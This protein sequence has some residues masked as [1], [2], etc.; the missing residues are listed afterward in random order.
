MVLIPPL[1]VSPV[2]RSRPVL[3]AYDGLPIELVAE[4]L[5]LYRE[6]FVELEI[7][8]AGRQCY[9]DA[10]FVEEMANPAVLKYVARVDGVAAAMVFLSNDLSTVPWISVPYYRHHFPDQ[11]RRQAIY[12]VGALLV[13]PEHRGG[14]ALTAVMHAAS[15]HVA[16]ADG[17]A[18]FDCCQHNVDALHLPRALALLA[19]RVCDVTEHKLDSQSFYAYALSNPK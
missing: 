13:H 15:R 11:F 3:Q 14:S 12:Y 5:A 17:L 9:T 7:A 19:R 8:A 18:A 4:F 2:R 16:E 6:S 1:S 10:E